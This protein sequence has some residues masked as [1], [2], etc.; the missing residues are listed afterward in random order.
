MTMSESSPEPVPSSRL[1]PLGRAESVSRRL[2]FVICA[3]VFAWGAGSLLSVTLREALET[4][5]EAVL[6]PGLRTIVAHWAFQR[7]WIVVMLVPASWLGGRFLGGSP[8]GFVM[9]ATIAGES[10]DLA[11]ASV[12]DGSPF[13][14]WEDVGG[15]AVSL[16]LALIPCFI[17][18]AVG[19][20]AFE[21]AKQQSLRDA[22]ALKSEYDAFIARSAGESPSSSEPPK[23]S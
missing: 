3:G 14:S 10:L 4:P 12:A 9:T 8:L 13:F 23:V 21:R 20:K 15:W 5:L 19:G 2:L 11:I 22:A 1:S 6:E 18:F 16:V 7:V 17:A